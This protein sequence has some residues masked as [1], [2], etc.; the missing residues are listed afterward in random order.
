MS[1]G[2][3]CRRH[4]EAHIIACDHRDHY[5]FYQFGKVVVRFRWPIIIFWAILFILAIPFAPRVTSHLKEGFGQTDTES[6]V[7][8][9]VLVE[10][11]DATESTI[12]LVFSSDSLT[13]DDPSY[14]AEM[15][16]ILSPIME[17]AE[18]KEVK[19]TPLFGQR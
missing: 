3:Y 8:L 10:E 14:V 13:V 11:L 18:V 6:R 12:T 1:R 16:R 19:W 17:T 2:E 7:A 5:M 15:Q 4:P 9:D